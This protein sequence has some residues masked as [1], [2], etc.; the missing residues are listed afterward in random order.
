MIHQMRLSVDLR[1]AI[2]DRVVMIYLYVQ[3]YTVESWYFFLFFVL[4]LLVFFA[5]A[6]VVVK[7]FGLS[8]RSVSGGKGGGGG[9]GASGCRGRG[10]GRWFGCPLLSSLP[11]HSCLA[12]LSCSRVSSCL[13]P[14]LPPSPFHLICHHFIFISFFFFF[15]VF[16]SHNQYHRGPKTSPT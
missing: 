2:Q 6:S 16:R 10:L 7:C 14:P 3:R 4:G 15:F 12:I 5:V 1:F 11:S 8:R 9:E 13:Q